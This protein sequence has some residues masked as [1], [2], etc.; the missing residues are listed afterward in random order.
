MSTPSGNDA[1]A[2]VADTGADTTTTTP[3]ESGV[4]NDTGSASF[5]C[6]PGE[7][8]A[9][10]GPGGCATNQ[11]CGADGS[12]Y[13]PCVCAPTDAAVRACVPGASIGCVGPGGCVSN[14]VCTADGTGYGACACVGDASALACVP[15]QSIACGGPG[16]CTSFQV[17]TSDG[18]GYGPCDCP[19]AGE[20][21]S[22]AWTPAQLPGLALWFDDTYGV[23]MD[24]THPGSVLHWL[25]KSG[26]GNIATTNGSYSPNGADPPWDGFPI[27]PEVLNGLDAVECVGGGSIS[28]ASAPNLDWGTGDFAI[29]MVMRT[30][31]SSMFELWTGNGVSVYANWTG[32]AT[33]PGTFVLETPIAPVTV[34]PP[35]TSKFQVL[36]ARGQSLDLSV[37]GVEATGGFN[38]TALAPGNILFCNGAS[39]EYAEIIAVQGNLSGANVANLSAYFHAKFDL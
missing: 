7:S 33:V 39:A 31:Q 3:A 36:I 38:T 2:K 20:D 23:V 14:Q 37:A 26:N 25:D 29:V 11:V 5:I 22:A 10:T 8:I 16:G 35:S 6:V 19:D 9:C 24:P 17:C 1:G 12:G 21:A 32:G 4:T 27:D 30:A 28:V 18:S 13:G 34:A 15:G